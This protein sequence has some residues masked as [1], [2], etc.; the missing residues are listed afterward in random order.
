MPA[1]TPFIQNLSDDICSPFFGPDQLLRYIAQ[2]AAEVFV[3]DRSNNVSSEHTIDGQPSAALFDKEGRLYVADPAAGAIVEVDR[4]GR[5]EFV[6]AEYDDKPLKG[7]NAIALDRSGTMYF[8]D[9]GMFGDTGMHNT[10]GSLFRISSTPT[11]LVLLPV[12]YETLAHPWGLA[13]S[14]DGRFLYVAETMK[15][16]VIRYFQRPT[17]AYHGSVFLQLAGR[18]GPSALACDQTGSLYVA[19]YDISGS[20]REGIVHVVSS[21]GEI[22]STITV[23]GP[24]ITGLAISPDHRMLFIAER[25]TKSVYYMEL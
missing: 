9:S 3:L 19:H 5:K 8:T 14:P 21:T 13:T 23:P 20:T 11:D 10:K 22:T 7:P 25:T 16:R 18:V 6:V 4:S 12:T 1:A 15:N 2:D 24:E 17:G